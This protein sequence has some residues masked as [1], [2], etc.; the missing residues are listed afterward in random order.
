MK[1]TLTIALSLV[2]GAAI[3]AP[4]FAQDQFPD[5]PANHWAFKELSELKAAGL[6]VGYPDGLFRGGRPASRYELAVAIHAVWTNLKNQQD[7]LRAQMEDLMKRL[8]GFATKADLDA[9]K[10]Q[11]DA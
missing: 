3:V 5:V 8:D 7:A 10:A 2:L 9:L 6:L 1:R 4:V 11:V